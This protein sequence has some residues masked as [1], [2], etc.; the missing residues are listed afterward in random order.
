[1][2]HEEQF[3]HDMIGRHHDCTIT[4]M[5]DEQ[6][7]HYHPEDSSVRDTICSLGQSHNVW[8]SI[9]PRR[10]DLPKKARG[11][12][13][14]ITFLNAMYAD[15]DIYDPNAHS[16]DDL[17]HSENEVLEV[18]AEVPEPPT[19]IVRSGHGLHV[20]WVF[21]EPVDLTEYDAS[22]AKKIYSGFCAFFLSLYQKK[23]WKLD[24]CFDI[25]RM[26]RAPGSLNHKTEPAVPCQITSYS[27]RYYDIADFEKYRTEEKPHT[28]VVYDA[29]SRTVGSAQRI[30]DGCA[31]VR[32]MLDDPN[33]VTEP[34]WKAQCSNIAL[35]PDGDALFHEWSAAYDGYSPEET[36]T[37]LRY[38]REAKM[39]C[40]CA[41]IRQT[42]GFDCPP[43]GCG[44]KA[45]IVLA[46]YSRT[47][48]LKNLL[49]RD[50][51][52]AEEIMDDYC[53]TLAAYAKENEPS[54][55]ALLKIKVKKLHIGLHDYEKAV[56]YFKEKSPAT[57]HSLMAFAGESCEILLDG[58]DLNGAQKPPKFS[59]SFQTGVTTYK[60]VKGFPVPVTICDTPVVITKRLENIENGQERLELAFYRNSH[61]KRLIV[62]RSTALNKSA[63][64][65]LAD[66]GFPVSSDNADGLVRYLVAYEACNGKC[67]PFERCTGK[68]GWIGN[69][70][71]PYVLNS[72]VVFEQDEGEDIC[73]ALHEQGDADEWLWNARKLRESFGARLMLAASFASPLL[74]KIRSRIVILHIWN[75]S[76]G[77]KTA[78][79]KF[80]LS[81]WGDPTVLMSSFN[82]TMVGLERK[83]AAMQHLPL[84]LDELQSLHEKRTPTSQVVYAL[85]N[86]IGRTR[87]NKNG[88]LQETVK[89]RNCILST[90]EQ[91]L[92]DDNSMDGVSSRVMEVYDLP[93]PDLEYGQFIH[94]FSERNFGFAGSA[95][96]RFIIERSEKLTEDLEKISEDIRKDSRGNLGAHDNSACAF[97]L[98]DWYAA[99]CIFDEEAETAYESA[100]QFGRSILHHLRENVQEDVVDRAWQFTKS[101]IA[102]NDSH[103]SA[104]EPI[105]GKKD[106]RKTYV[107]ASILRKCLT[108]A[109]FNC[110]KSI[111]GFAERGY[112]EV[113]TDSTGKQNCCLQKKIHNVNVRVYSINPEDDNT[114]DE[115]DDE[116]PFLSAG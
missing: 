53:L 116:F 1:M 113:V 52:T 104:Q 27:D 99:M 21:R 25:P 29:D 54:A 102:S 34:E 13:R 62:P 115:E 37:K 51:L 93:I 68:I 28:D 66:S 55:F 100:V 94:Q 38:S 35:T 40:T 32:K 39:P 105:Y 84:G 111:K 12:L 2:T 70:F 67:I 44:V 110:R 9:N 43:D 48:Q 90:G 88:G 31:F 42:L 114:D 26:L 59:V 112:L 23:G 56:Q 80:A 30:M 33:N 7:H 79:L 61:W 106:G 10:P 97:A 17:P 36:D 41:Y 77:G 72:P 107:I 24:N 98:A 96:I 22:K 14:D 64:I 73:G 20:Y 50:D 4:L 16:Q 63:M 71:Y 92:S 86:G 75:A 76:R 74:S 47:E 78:M 58:I 108:D 101:W 46:H 11:K 81:V 83:A 6:V 85:G 65:R 89:W 19:Y 45:P 109:G 8:L 87:G 5:V 57:K 69:E 15:C 82:T 95:F 103:F 3:Y 91:T 60:I 49:D 18:L